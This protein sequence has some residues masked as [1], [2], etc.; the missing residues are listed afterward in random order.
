MSLGKE[1]SGHISG[2][3][4]RSYFP[5][6]LIRSGERYTFHSLDQLKQNKMQRVTMVHKEECPNV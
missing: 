1:H 2:E 5:S 4:L 6:L 3:I